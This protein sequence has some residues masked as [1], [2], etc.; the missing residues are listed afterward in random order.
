MKPRTKGLLH[1]L[2]LFS[3]FGSKCR[4]V[5]GCLY[6]WIEG[7]L[8]HS[9]EAWPW[10]DIDPSSTSLSLFWIYNSK[11]TSLRLLMEVRTLSHGGRRYIVPT[12]FVNVKRN[13]NGAHELAQYAQKKTCIILPGH[14]P[15]CVEQHVLDDC[16]FNT[17]SYFLAK[18][19]K[20]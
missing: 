10:N 7:F 9:N 5:Q 2:Y 19:G 14:V 8:A 12:R 11:S 18:K 20:I 4:V 3:P 17:M 16:N 13:W 6:L 15:S 1:P